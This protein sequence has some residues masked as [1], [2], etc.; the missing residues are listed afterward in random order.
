M[1]LFGGIEGRVQS[2]HLGGKDIGPQYYCC[3]DHDGDDVLLSSSR[4]RGMMGRLGEGRGTVPQTLNGAFTKT[5]RKGVCTL[6]Q[7]RSSDLA[8][9]SVCCIEDINWANEAMGI[10][11][12]RDWQGQWVV[13]AIASVINM[14]CVV[15][16]FSADRLIHAYGE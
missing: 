10:G 5:C 6:R 11:I 12:I 15:G 4:E 14:M 1:G 3:D 16:C 8:K 7:T 13:F 9:K 2:C